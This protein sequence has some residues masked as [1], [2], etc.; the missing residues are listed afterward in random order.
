MSNRVRTVKMRRDVDTHS[1]IHEASHHDSIVLTGHR[2]FRYAKRV[3]AHIRKIAS[4][5]SGG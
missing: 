4:F 2:T 5:K 3:H 1:L